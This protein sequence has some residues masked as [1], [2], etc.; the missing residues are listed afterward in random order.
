MAE[1]IEELVLKI[2]A[3]VEG[4]KAGLSS[5]AASSEQL[6]NKVSG[7]SES[8]VASFIKAE[9]AVE[10][11]KKGFEFLKEETIDYVKESYKNIEANDRLAVKLGVT[12]EFIAALKVQGDEFGISAEQM[13]HAVL[14]LDRSL[15]AITDSSSPAAKA[16]KEL[17]LDFQDVLNMKPEEQYKVIAERFGTLTSQTERV[18]VATALYGREGIQMV[19]ILRQ[20]A[21]GFEEA[22]HAAKKYGLALNEADTSKVVQANKAWREVH[23]VI[24]GLANTI[25]VKLAPYMVGIAEAFTDA[26][27]QGD[28][29]GETIDGVIKF[30]IQ[31]VDGFRAEIHGLEIAWAGVKVAVVGVGAG[32]V[33]AIDVAVRSI[34]YAGETLGG[35][36]RALERTEELITQAFKSGFEKALSAVKIFA[37]DALEEFSTLL[38]KVNEGMQA[39]G[40]KGASE[41]LTAGNNVHYAAVRLKAD[42]QG[43]SK[44]AGIAFENA[45][46]DASYAWDHVM[47]DWNETAV[48]GLTDFAQTM[49]DT[50][51]ETWDD[52]QTIMDEPFDTHAFEDWASKVV[53]K[54]NDVAAKVQKQRTEDAKEDQSVNLKKQAWDK[55]TWDQK[56][57]YATS[58]ANSIAELMEHGSKRQFEIGKKLQLAA[59]IADTAGGIAKTFE[60]FGW[61]ALLGPAEAVAAAG[62]VQIAK[63]SSMQYGGGGG[64]GGGGAGVSAGA[65]PNAQSIP[66]SGV[67]GTRDGG[68]N[69]NIS[70]N[71]DN[72][73]AQG[74]RNLLGA[75]NDQ[76]RDGV[77]IQSL[78]VSG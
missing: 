15:G 69:I 32:I 35:F 68:Q 52:L 72:Y 2:S 38:L 3:D 23:L 70:L 28:G 55:Q 22:E 4:V 74:V 71:G 40:I 34:V 77:N 29:F 65:L 31:L 19:G 18:H 47:P 75:I 62:A 53:A 5:V 76:I 56:L 50:F 14:H 66:Q 27:T 16:L 41:M 30:V 58:T 24:E 36:G 9:L 11:L 45:A 67:T 61:Y 49:R 59:A 12:T 1:P 20:G 48:P 37:A 13:G 78:S 46:A 10:A 57:G 73:S 54:V 63:I 42:A 33:T 60:Q 26:A 43:A 25:A 39:A 7:H 8:M 6:A 64:G 44:D 21:A 51:D 17:G